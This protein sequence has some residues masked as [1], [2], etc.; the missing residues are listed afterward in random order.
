M[1]ALGFIAAAFILHTILVVLRSRR[2]GA[3]RGAAGDGEDAEAYER[4]TGAR[5][6]ERSDTEPPGNIAGA[7]YSYNNSEFSVSDDTH[8]EAASDHFSDAVSSGGAWDDRP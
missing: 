8:F 5:A 7:T 3:S 2:Q 4:L 1:S 6:Y